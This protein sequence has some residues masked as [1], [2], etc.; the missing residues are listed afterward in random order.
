MRIWD[1]NES[2][3]LSWQPRVATRM[4]NQLKQQLS[5]LHSPTSFHGVHEDSVESTKNLHGLHEDSTETP[6]RLHGNPWEHFLLVPNRLH[7]LHMESRGTV[8][9]IKD[10]IRTPWNTVSWILWRLSIDSKGQPP[11][12]NLLKRNH[13]QKQMLTAGVE[14]RTFWNLLVTI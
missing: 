2:E 4:W 12:F 13:K 5:T 14:L 7:R 9:N 3:W 8:W 11:S 1:Q 10:S 6:Q